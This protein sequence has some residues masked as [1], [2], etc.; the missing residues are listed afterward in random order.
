MKPVFFKDTNAFRKW[1][2]KNHATEKELWV[3]Y[4]KV[5]TGKPSITWSESVDQALCY[6]WIDGI[7]KSV[8]EDSYMNRFTPRKPKSNWSEVNIKK[9]KALIKKG[10]MQPAG[11]EP[12]NNRV[13][14]KSGEY[15]Y[16]NKP[17]KLSPAL[18]K[19]FKANKKAWK[20][21]TGQSPSYQRLNYYRVMSAK[22]TATQLSR[23]NKLIAASE[24]EQKLN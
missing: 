21:F 17:E 9:V 24:K 5:H 6:G 7:R 14:K 19:I 16:E 23:L 11:L 20:F 8:D 13:K 18:E 10:L 2:E 3:G 12:Y 1:L 15:S 22:Q 4:Y